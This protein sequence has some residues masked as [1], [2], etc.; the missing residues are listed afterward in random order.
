[1]EGIKRLIT[2]M[3]RADIILVLVILVFSIV[4]IFL[5]ILF[6]PE[7]GE[8]QLVVEQAGQELFRKDFPREDG[9]E[10]FSFRWQGDEYQARLEFEN[11]RVRL[12]RLSKEVVPLDIHE[13]MG[14]IQRP[15]Q[16]I[17]ALPVQMVISIEGDRGEREYD[18][19]VGSYEN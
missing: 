3:T 2:R 4:G 5:P 10:E 19:V 16:M 14:W 13:Q 7:H 6:Q 9:I 15:G 11:N 18:G 17:V 12:H 8:Y 1:M